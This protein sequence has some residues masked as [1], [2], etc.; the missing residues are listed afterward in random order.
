MTPFL[1]DKLIRF[2][3]GI[4]IDLE[5]CL[6]E[7]R[8]YNRELFLCLPQKYAET[9]PRFLT[10]FFQHKFTLWHIELNIYI[11]KT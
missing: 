10:V 8:N 4:L 1:K 7:L 11:W 9:Q 5:N 3:R 6:K 2:D